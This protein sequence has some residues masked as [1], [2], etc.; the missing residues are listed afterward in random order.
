V[1]EAA[2]PAAVPTP[3]NSSSL[4]SDL[5]EQ[6]KAQLPESLFAAVSAQLGDIQRTVVSYKDEL[7]YRAMKIQLLEEKLRLQRI[8][9]Y[10]PGSEKLSNL[11][12]ELLEFEPGVS[13]TEVAAESERDAL[14]PTPEKK[15]RRKHPG[16]QT[17]PADLPRV[18]RVIACTPEQC[19]C[20]SC[21]AGTKVIGYEVSEVLDVKPAEYF[22]QVTKREKRACKACEEQGVAMAPLPVRIIARS[23]VSDRI[24]IDTI[25][26]KYAD[27]NPLYRQSVIFLRDAG[28][29]IGRATM[30]G[31]VM[32]VGELLAPVVGAMRHELLAGSYIQA[33]ETTVD[34]QMHDRRGKNHQGYLWQ[35]GT[36]GGATIFDFQMGRGRE[37]PAH[38]LDKFEGILQT[39]GYVS[40]VRGVGGPKMVHAACWSHARRGFVDA[41]KLNKLDAASIGIVDLM[42]QLFAID[43]RARNEKMDHAARHVLR[44][45]EAPP[46]LAKIS[47]QILALSKNVLPKSA[48]GEACAYTVKLWKK[49]TCFLEYPELELSNNLAENSMR[50]VALGRKNWIHIGSQQAGPRVAAILSVVESCRRLRIPVRDYLNEIL[51]GLASRSIQQLADLTPAAWGAR[52]NPPTLKPAA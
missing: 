11:Q 39:D 26:G 47:V 37:G 50:G 43:A 15:K 45:Q 8:A 3:D 32:T 17:L 10:G 29:D 27:H 18:E 48:A 21:G 4:S 22:V 36:P 1:S 14:P 35:Y 13:N 38:F 40:Y 16:R 25:V 33:D 51:P 6:L 44:Q 7:Q 12:L 52:H 23:L 19:V 46:L 20:G 24:I 34:V 5:L 30:C 42:D 49:L 41:I 31:W 28:I 9:K 2:Q